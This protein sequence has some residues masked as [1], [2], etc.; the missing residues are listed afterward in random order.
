M[1]MRTANIEITETIIGK[2]ASFA[3]RKAFG[4]VKDIGQKRIPKT[5][6]HM[7]IHQASSVVSG[8]R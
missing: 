7:V 5:P 6:W 1:P 3:A 8:E 4:R 2:A